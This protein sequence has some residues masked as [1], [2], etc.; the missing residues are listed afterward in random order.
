MG[1]AGVTAFYAYVLQCAD[2]TYY[3]GAASDPLRRLRQHSGELHGGAK[4]TR[5]RRPCVLLHV[6]EY[7]TRSDAMRREAHIKQLSRREKEELIRLGCGPDCML[8]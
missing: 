3:T 8:P 4:Y 6:E 5:T 7:A 2:G 1:E